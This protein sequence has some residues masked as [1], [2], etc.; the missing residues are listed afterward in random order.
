MVN[1]WTP[2]TEEELVAALDDGRLDEGQHLDFKREL[3]GGKKANI[4]LA[5]DLAMFA[6]DGG[7]LIFGVDDPQAGRY[8]PAPVALK[9]L[10]ERIEQVATSRL[11]PPL[12]VDVR[13]LPAND[14]PTCGYVVVRVPA[15]PAAPH[16]VET[17]RR[18]YGRAG[19]TREKLPDAQVRTVL[20]SRQLASQPIYDLLDADVARD[21]IPTDFRTHAHL[22]VVA[23]ARYPAEDLVLADV[24]RV[25]GSWS[26]WFHKELLGVPFDPR[27][28][29]WSP[30]LKNQASNVGRR[31]NGAALYS[32]YVGQDRSL[33]DLIDDPE[34]LSRYEDN[35]LDLEVDEDGTLH[36]FCGRGSD[37]LREVE[38][39]IPAVVAGLVMRAVQAAARITDLTGYVGTWDFAVAVTGLR[40]VAPHARDL[41]DHSPAYSADEYRN[42][43]AADTAEL[44]SSS[45]GCTERLVGRLLRGL[46]RDGGIDAVFPPEQ[47]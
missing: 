24:E 45:R 42:R 22:H 3:S 27:L 12:Y 37:T 6:N 40:G 32:Y 4:E 5:R 38:V 36:L 7:T 2:S 11:E 47:P 30:D 34:K 21:P 16:M 9:G 10:R 29:S 8:S 28:G 31:A 39:L 25:G 18:Y 19:T 41:T 17:D 13:T 23:R 44:A 20:T 35:L 14:D 46:G 15:S 26:T 33:P 1:R 43:T